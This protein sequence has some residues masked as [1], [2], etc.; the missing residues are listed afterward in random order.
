M[1]SQTH[2]EPRRA[3]ISD[4]DDDAMLNSAQTKARCGNVTD[5]CIWRWQRDARVQFPLPTKINSRNYWRLADLRA[6]QQRHATKS[7]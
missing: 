5:M 1:Q 7:A 3:A 6:W 4:L 2:A